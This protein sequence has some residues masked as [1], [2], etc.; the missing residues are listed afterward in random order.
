MIR[1]LLGIPIA[2]LNQRRSL[3]MG[4]ISMVTR[5]GLWCLLL[6]CSLLAALVVRPAYADEER[7]Q[8]WA[9]LIGVDDYAELQDLRFAGSD[10]RAFAE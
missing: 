7:P 5:A 10:Q 2:S 1:R 4:N 3:S 8:K 6:L 9:L